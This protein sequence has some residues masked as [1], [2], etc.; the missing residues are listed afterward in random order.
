MPLVSEQQTMGVIVLA[1]SESQQ[2]FDASYLEL[3]RDFAGHAA[4]ALT[5]STAREYARELSVLAD[6]ERIARDLHDRV[7]QRVFAVAIDLQSTVARVRTPEVADRIDAAIDQLQQ[8]INDIRLS[9]FDLKQS[10]DGQNALA[11][12]IQEAVSRHTENTDIMVTLQTSGPLN[13]VSPQLADDVEAVVI[14]ALSNAVRHSGADTI[15]VVLGVDDELHLEICDNGN[16]IDSLNNRN[17]GS[18]NMIQRAKQAGGHC[19]ITSPSGGGTRVSWM[20]P[21]LPQ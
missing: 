20:A 1:R 18:D 5:L 3:A 13:V 7:I 14:E 16:G 6:R 17:S 2:P 21:L 12:R 9:I 4:I 10:T 15:T 19:E 11:H 8:V